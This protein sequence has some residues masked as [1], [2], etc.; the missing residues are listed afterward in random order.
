MKHALSFLAGVALIS[1]CIIATRSLPGYMFLLGYMVSIASIVILSRAIGFSRI[2]RF[3]LWLSKSETVFVSCGPGVAARREIRSLQTGRASSAVQAS[4]RKSD[5]GIAFSVN[6][7]Q[8]V[9]PSGTR[10]VLMADD[11]RQTGRP[12][13]PRGE[14]PTRCNSS[15][16]RNAGRPKKNSVQSSN[17]NNVLPT[18]QQEVL[19][20]LI[21]LGVSFGKAEEAVHAAAKE[22]GGESFDEMFRTAISLLNAGKS[23]RAAA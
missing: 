18:T 1:L 16:A 12:L 3:F 23:R 7:G 15:A 19:S 14:L 11:A 17:G 22:H 9:N 21:N 20:A 10:A 5:V 4:G 8:Q 2:A 13:A 6:R